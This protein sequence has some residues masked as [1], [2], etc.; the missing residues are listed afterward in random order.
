V[1]TALQLRYEQYIA[2][3]RKSAKA[4]KE[5]DDAQDSVRKGQDALRRTTEVVGAALVVAFGKKLVDAASN[6]NE[7]QNK[8]NVVFGKS[9]AA[10]SAWAKT[11]AKSFGMSER[12][13]LEAAGTYGNLFVS[14]G[15]ADDAASSMSTKMV[16]LAGDLASFNNAD[17]TE[18]L[19][20]LRSGL[21]GETEPLRR[22]GVNLNDADLRQKALAM[23]LTTTTKDVLPPAIKAQAAYALILEQTKTAQGD[24]ARTSDS[25][26]NQQRILNAEWENTQA[27]LGQALLPM[28]TKT[29]EVLNDLLGIFNQLPDPVKGLTVAV[30][31]LG[32]GFVLLAPK[33]AA[34]KALLSDLTAGNSKL[35]KGLGAVGGFLAGPWGLAIAGA[36]IGLGAFMDAQANTQAAVDALTA[37]L[38]KQNGTA[39]AA[40]FEKI[41]TELSKDINVDDWKKLPFTLDEVTS[42]VVNGGHELETFRGK[43]DAFID[44]NSVGNDAMMESARVASALGSSIENQVPDLE[45]AR[46]AWFAHKAAQDAAVKAAGNTKGAVAG[47]GGAAKDAA[48]EVETLDDALK[49]LRGEKQ[50]TAQAIA[51]L[52]ESFDDAAKAVK[53]LKNATRDNGSA[54]NLGTE[55]GRKAQDA[56]AGIAD[57]A[58]EA[59]EAMNANG[60]SAT[61]INQKMSRAR[62][63]FIQTAMA[64]GLTEEAARDLARQWGL[65]PKKVATTVEAKTE[66]AKTDVRDL[67]AWIAQ[68][69]ATIKVDAKAGT[70]GT[71]GGR[72]TWEGSASGGYIS[73]PGSSTSDSI[74]ARLSDGEYVIR[75]SSVRKYGQG[76]LDQVNAGTYANGGR[77]RGRIGSRRYDFGD[78]ADI[79]KAQVGSAALDFDFTAYGQA[80]DRA[81]AAVAGL[82]DAQDALAQARERVNMAGT[83]EEQ[84]QAARDL[85][86]AEQDLAS[87]KRE[88]AAAEKAKTAAKPTSANIL[89]S[90]RDRAAKLDRFRRDLRTLSK[91]GLSPVILQQLLEAGIDEGGEMAAALV[92]DPSIIASLNKTQAAINADART[93]GRMFGGKGDATTGSSSSGGGTTGTTGT[94]SERI[95]IGFENATKPMVLKMDTRDVW[96][97]LLRLKRDR[98]GAKLG[99]D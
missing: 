7:Q 65:V 52:E 24:F 75:A 27:A 51:D 71:G 2:G 12:A 90:F 89:S 25:L 1:S 18:V 73:G 92:K 3:A 98:N 66:E 50:S 72:Q 86:K 91:R 28:A 21:V 76:M 67:V 99:L 88:S 22:F 4:T 54:L 77:V 48:G 14:M 13:A 78:R 64:A 57:K 29:V 80:V 45:D 15:L 47:V 58:F 61:A 8:A 26:A 40:T 95:A 69:R 79:R 46:R 30:G 60:A 35:G 81:K 39:T 6:L 32:A 63:Q 83:P 10:V 84:A 62:S 34:T 41:A 5:L 49:R 96:Q 56:L 93:L 53:G 37:S 36:T 38:D 19:D 55:A 68:Q 82:A 74:P 23:G 11:S 20:A 97:G 31:A 16:E 59:T 87:A 17:P 85:A 42:A 9:A 94:T 33:I 70:R 43:L 44:A